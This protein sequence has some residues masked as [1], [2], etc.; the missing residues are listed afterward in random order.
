MQPRRSLR[1]C[2]KVQGND[3]ASLSPTSP[4]PFPFASCSTVYS[5]RVHFPPTPSLASTHLTH[6]PNQYDRAPI[7]V[8]PN[9]CAL[10]ER[11][12]RTYYSHGPDRDRHSKPRVKGSYFHPHAYEAT[13][14]EPVD[15]PPPS[16]HPPPLVP[17]ISSESDESD[18]PMT[19]PP[20]P[21]LLPPLPFHLPNTAHPPLGGMGGAMEDA[22]RSFLPHPPSPTMEKDKRKRSPSRSRGQLRQARRSEFAAPELDGCLGGF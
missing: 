13:E 7:V 16:F 14:R 3:Q 6:S 18:T 4:S 21:Q 19:T 15:V 2:L 12:E 9:A 22:K 5:P 10:P 17:D 11:N 1:P 20:D 8:T